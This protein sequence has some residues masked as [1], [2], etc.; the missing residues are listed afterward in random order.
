[1]KLVIVIE[2]IDLKDR[3]FIKMF[4]QSLD[5]KRIIE[6]PSLHEIKPTYRKEINLLDLS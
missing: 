4:E 1:M 6:E 2:L 3:P 5:H